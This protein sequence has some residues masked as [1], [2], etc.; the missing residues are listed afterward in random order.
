LF[1]QWLTIK[2]TDDDKTVARKKKLMKSYKSKIRFQQ[3][4]IQQK[5][6]QSNWQSFLKGKGSKKKTGKK[7]GYSGNTVTCWNDKAHGLDAAIDGGIFLPW[8]IYC[9]LC[10]VVWLTT[11]LII[12]RTLGMAAF[13]Y[14]Y[15]ISAHDM[16]RFLSC[17]YDGQTTPEWPRKGIGRQCR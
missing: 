17:E 14:W 4:D 7:H 3:M 11:V 5:E 8:A 13:V 12:S 16:G 9:A 2:E 6:K 10:T 15:M 1:S